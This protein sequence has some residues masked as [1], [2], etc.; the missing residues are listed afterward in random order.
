MKKYNKLFAYF[1][2]FWILILS[3]N[4]FSEEKPKPIGVIQEVRNETN[5][6]L[7]VTSADG[8]YQIPA[9]VTKDIGHSN[10]T[11]Q[12]YILGSVTQKIPNFTQSHLLNLKP[13]HSKGIAWLDQSLETPNKATVSFRARA[14]QEIQVVF[15]TKEKYDK[16]DY[17]WKIIIG[18][19]NNKKSVIV[20]DNK[21]V[22]EVH[23]S[24]NFK[25]AARKGRFPL[26]WISINNGF[27]IVG[28]GFPGENVFLSW[29]DPEPA[30]LI[31]NVGFSSHNKEVDYTEIRTLLPITT[32]PLT[33][34]YYKFEKPIPKGKVNIKDCWIDKPFRIKDVGGI[35]FQA[36]PTATDNI[37]ITF[38]NKLITSR[39][40]I[41]Y[42]F[43]LGANYIALLRKGKIANSMHI[44]KSIKPDGK[45]HQYWA[46]I[47]NGSLILGYEKTGEKPLLIW[48]DPKPI[49]N[50]N[51]IGLK[52]SYAQLKTSEEILG[53]QKII[54]KSM[55]QLKLINGWTNYGKPY[56]NASIFKNKN[57]VYVDGVIKNGKWGE[58]AILPPGYRPTTGILHFALRT[59]DRMP[60]IVTVHPNGK[61][62][63]VGGQK[64]SWLS[65][66]GI[67]FSIVSGKKLQFMPDWTNYESGKA[68]ATYRKIGD[69]C[70]IQGHVKNTRNCRIGENDNI[71]KLPAE[72]RPPQTLRFNVA[73]GDTDAHLEILIDGRIIFQGSTTEQWQDI[74]LDGIEFSI[75]KGFHLPLK[76]EWKKYYHDRRNFTKPEYI[77]TYNRC[78]VQGVVELGESNHL[79]TLPLGFRPQKRLIFNL[80]HRN[81]GYR[82]DVLSNG[83]IKWI[84]GD[85]VKN[86]QNGLS[87]SGI[88]F[89]ASTTVEPPSIIRRNITDYK[90]ISL[91]EIE[92]E[93]QTSKTL[94]FD[95][96][97]IIS[98][99][100]IDFEK[101]KEG[102]K[103]KKALFKYDGSIT[104]ISPFYYELSQ[105]LEGNAIFIEDRIYRQKKRITAMKKPGATY[106]Y[107]LAIKA[108]GAPEIKEIISPTPSAQEVA[109]EVQAKVMKIE[110]KEQRSIAQAR[111]EMADTL[112]NA[113]GAIGRMGQGPISGAVAASAGSAMVGAGVGLAAHATHLKEKAAHK[114]SSA[115]KLNLRREQMYTA[116]ENALT[117]KFTG[118]MAGSTSIPPEAI[119]NKEKIEQVLAEIR[120]KKYSP[121]IL[122]HFSILIDKYNY[123]VDRIIHPYVVSDK[124]T[125]HEILKGITK[126]VNAISK[127]NELKE[128]PLN[129]Y[130]NLLTLLINVHDNY[131]IYEEGNKTDESY[132]L[133]FYFGL[134]KIFYPIF[135]EY[136]ATTLGFNIAPFHG[137]YV[138]LK[139]KFEAP[140]KG[141]IHFEAQGIAEIIIGMAQKPGKAK[142]TGKEFYEIAIGK[143][144]NTASDINLKIHDQ[145]Y[146]TKE[147]LETNNKQAVASP[148]DF[149]KYWVS[150][151][152]GKISLGTGEFKPVNKIIEWQ[153]PYP[154]KEIERIGLSSGNHDITYRG[155]IL[156]P[157]LEEWKKMSTAEILATGSLSSNQFK[158][159]T[160][161]LTKKLTELQKKDVK[162]WLTNF[163]SLINNMIGQPKDALKQFRELVNRVKNYN[164]LFP[165]RTS[166]TFG[167]YKQKLDS[168]IPKADVDLIQ[169]MQSAINEIKH[170]TSETSSYWIKKLIHVTN[171]ITNNEKELRNLSNLINKTKTYIEGLP[172]WA[173]KTFGEKKLKQ[174]N[175]E[176]I[177]KAEKLTKNLIDQKI[178]SKMQ[179]APEI[180]LRKIERE[181]KED[182]KIRTGEEEEEEEY[183]EDDDEDSED[184]DDEEYE[185]DD[186]E[187]Y[188]DDDEEDDEDYENEEEYEDE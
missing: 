14:D 174:L 151:S 119:K 165:E 170:V 84:T 80:N 13:M 49:P 182:E 3:Q 69:M 106:T 166:K 77:K 184:E 178:E 99:V 22:S 58:I 9:K 95:N 68:E 97:Q 52:T 87:L 46:S 156:G 125:K 10:V 19:W 26:F 136:N 132:K 79:A 16:N 187:E 91:K 60:A 146:T 65:L 73:Y 150:I 85:D 124:A 139:D 179:K 138:W 72:C 122:K 155:V 114:E 143:W 135:E 171:N 175:D 131:Y 117:E 33:S 167:R 35:A 59:E 55:P 20:K 61:I 42:E 185:N 86:V 145:T 25:A 45:K 144:N 116:L 66:S 92:N 71:A 188:K 176:I 76:G 181:A 43:I 103:Q 160:I 11:Y 75:K 129:D 38:G 88:S 101:K 36:S 180:K 98:P 168:L 157:P 154:I 102:Y 113:G 183:E 134:S 54:K 44:P 62:T 27:I 127:Y 83:E 93:K 29:R 31:E 34:E 159:L 169:I 177:P 40:Q 23:I 28:E 162:E 1:I 120:T 128:K 148:V 57:L 50:I 53:T 7:T 48:N 121:T 112:I 118:R 30:K 4:L 104:V 140:E 24:Q 186:D 18:G 6:S 147:I 67:H 158:K 56:T 137:E 105:S 12:P 108:D 81:I 64:N 21:I 63:W 141:S 39:N 90:Q 142:N 153:D 37:C 74:N 163:A 111:M 32:L 100:Y 126:L 17:N 70:Y 164:K 78:Y 123:I 8:E 82:A 149:K 110:V 115:S 94:T 109:W 15:A 133:K 130:K 89:P 172:G 51:N 5:K 107:L 161:E 152:N 173:Q 47:N 96:V 2:Y 41:P